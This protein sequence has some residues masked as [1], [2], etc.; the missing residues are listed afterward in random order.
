MNLKNKKIIL[1]IFT[2]ISIIFDLYYAISIYTGKINLETSSGIIQISNNEQIILLVSCAIVNLI[3]LFFI[4]KNPLQHKKK[5]IILNIVQLMIGNIFNVIS[6][7][8]NIIILAIKT[9][10]I[11]EEVK[12]KKE[13]PVLEDITKYKWY[14]YFLIFVFLFIICYT[15]V[16]NLLPIPN[17]KIAT[18]TSIV[19]LY[20]IQT[21]LLVIPMWDELK[22]DYKVF[23]DN[24]KLYLGNMLPRFGAI[25][26]FY[27][28][29][30]LSLVSFIGT[31]PTNQAIINTW[32]LYITAFVAIIIAP[33][34]EE[35]M[36][37]G[38]IKKFIKNDIL[39]VIVSSLIFGSLHVAVA[40]SLQQL[41][42]I[43]PYSLLGLAFSLNYVKTRNIASNIFL[44][45]AWNTIAVLA[46]LLLKIL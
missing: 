6:G 46:M 26:L 19:I 18:I 39:F 23:K 24:F 29:S 14:V 41:L 27:L 38:F 45:S 36:F 37:R 40:G 28:I 4:I 25:I 9:K 1:L 33:L 15:P 21:F 13:L 10:D 22:R 43:I 8:I 7:I 12:E 34:T 32:P 16:T 17:T 44:H 30:N 2:I 31:I 11:S 3:S 20:I 35:L 5:I 42:F